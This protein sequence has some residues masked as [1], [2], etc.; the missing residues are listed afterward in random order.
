VTVGTFLD[1]VQ[2][3]QVGTAALALERAIASSFAEDHARP[4]G[5][6][7][8]RRF[9]ICERLL[10]HLRGDLGW[11]LQR[12]LDHLPNYLRCELDRVPWEPEARTIW[13]P[14]DGPT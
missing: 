14:G 5:D 4:T 6:E 10:R 1:L 7:V 13:T 11:G 12:V 2:E 8:R 3:D 9:A